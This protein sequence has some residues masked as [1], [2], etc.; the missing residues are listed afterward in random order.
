MINDIQQISSDISGL[1]T[2]AE[3]IYRQTEQKFYISLKNINGINIAVFPKSE[4]YIF[5]SYNAGDYD[6]FR[7]LRYLYNKQSIFKT[8]LCSLCSIEKEDNS[9]I[10]SDEQNQLYFDR[11]KSPSILIKYEFVGGIYNDLPP[12]T[13][14]ITG[15]NPQYYYNHLLLI[16]K[17]HIP[18]Y[19]VFIDKRIFKDLMF[20]LR[21]ASSSEPNINAFFNGNAGSE[22]FHYHVHLTNTENHT[23]NDM[24]RPKEGTHSRISKGTYIYISQIVKSII[25]VN[26]NLDTLFKIMGD[27]MKS[28]LLLK[29][30]YGND[31]RFTANFFYKDLSF[32]VTIQIFNRNFQEWIYGDSNYF[33]FP[34]SFMLTVNKEFV[35]KT[36]EEFNEFKRLMT[37]NY[38]QAYIDPRDFIKSNKILEEDSDQYYLNIVQETNFTNVLNFSV[39]NMYVWFENQKHLLSEDDLNQLSI[40]ILEFIIQ[41]NCLEKEKMCTYLE[42]GKFK[43]L[44]GLGLNIIKEDDL[45]RINTT[46]L[47][48][49]SQMY[50]LEELNK[51]NNKIKTDYLYFSGKFV[52]EKILKTFK[53]LLLITST[54]DEKNRIFDEVDTIE[55]WMLYKFKQIGEQ[56][57]SGTITASEIKFPNIDLI[58]KI[59]KTQDY[60]KQAEF[61]HEFF[62]SMQVNEI[63]N[64]IP[65]FIYC[66]GGFF[67][68]STDYETLCDKGEGRD[69]SYLLL[70]NVK[71]SRTFNRRLVLPNISYENEVNDLVDSIYQVIV[72][73]YFGW[74]TTNFTH[75]DLHMDNIMEYD[76][77]TNPNFLKLFTFD[78]EVIPKIDKI[79]FRYYIDKNNLNQVILVP[80][81]YLYLII[82]YGTSFVN[83]MPDNSRFVNQNNKRLYG[84]TSDKQNKIFDVYTLLISFF[85]T[86]F[87]Q[88]PSLLIQNSSYK[89]NI[90]V[91]FLQKFLQ[92]YSNLWDKEVPYIMN[93]LGQNS[94]INV[95]R[96]ETYEKL[97]LSFIKDE[98]KLLNHQ[99]LH[100]NFTEDNVNSDFRGAYRVMMWLYENH[101]THQDLQLE[102]PNTYIFNW[103]F[104][105]EGVFMGIK[106]N[107]EKIENLKNFNVERTRIKNENVKKLMEWV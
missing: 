90:L 6:D 59:M 16:S 39:E 97:F 23:I 33:M 5:T 52:Q 102:N 67:C 34:A 71:N 42:F 21:E 54:Q 1:F 89:D 22:I 74:I 84:M 13:Y 11:N 14:N 44:L 55:K 91:R 15:T 56:S 69:Y 49:T 77:I 70:E 78:N 106:P 29:E 2:Q 51:N 64:L 25:F 87:V 58:M 19:A 98:Y 40:I 76:F 38:N 48:I 85:T 4:Q 83:D 9:L 41:N 79:I 57:A 63:R 30:E 82:D 100:P 26:Q 81:K 37:E 75:Y 95:N 101:Y 62:V 18:T 45:K 93:K 27:Y 72:S 104:I 43:Y 12:L 47:F 105:P 68:N 103:G 92:A 3:T 46:D 36:R 99:Y 35:P 107:L 53:N 17:N 32:F 60:N 86:I 50:Y 66:Y 73:L 7:D 28:I 96:K 61:K 65:N 94:F 88:R 8:Y 20:F 10:I 24:S 31:L 80:A